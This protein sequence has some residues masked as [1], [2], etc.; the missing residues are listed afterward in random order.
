MVEFVTKRPLRMPLWEDPNKYVKS[1]NYS[2]ERINNVLIK[3][4]YLD[5]AKS[6]T[7]IFL[8]ACYFTLKGIFW[9]PQ[10]MIQLPHSILPVTNLGHSD[11]NQWIKDSEPQFLISLPNGG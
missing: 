2:D 5:T 8:V 6:K 1:P 10:K 4:R 7:R 3:R 9:E 11:F